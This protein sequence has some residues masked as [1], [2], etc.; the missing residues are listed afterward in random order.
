MPPKSQKRDK[1]VQYEVWLGG[2][3]FIGTSTVDLPTLAQ[4]ADE[5]KGAGIMGGFEMPTLGHFE[6]MTTTLNFTAQEPNSAKLLIPEWQTLEFRAVQQIADT[7]A[8]GIPVEGLK[9]VM[10]AM[11]KSAEEGSLET[12]VA[13]GG[14][15]E[16]E[17]V[18]YKK[19]IA[20]KTAVE[21]DKLSGKFVVDGKDYYSSVKKE[22]GY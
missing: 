2:N 17:V 19:V 13:I 7:N 10:K 9:Y 20:G 18:Y 4:A 6:S 22:L 3:E 12:A 21:I 5:V 11:A 1:L 15:I 16:M 14:S 8:T